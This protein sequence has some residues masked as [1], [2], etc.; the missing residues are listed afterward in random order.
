MSQTFQPL[1]LT[2]GAVVVTF[3]AFILGLVALRQRW[4]ETARAVALDR[5]LGAAAALVYVV[6]V[7][8]PLLPR[9]FDLAWSLPLHICD[10][11]TLCVPL[12]LLW[13]W[14]RPWRPP[15]AILYFWGLG[16]STQGFVTPDL[17]DGPARVGFWMF[18]LAHFS[19]VGGALYDVIG[20]GFRP[21]W[22]DYGVAVA[23]G[24]WYVALVV[25]VNMALGVNYGYVG[26]GTPGQPTLIDALGPWP[27]RVAIIL[28][29]AAAATALLMLPWVI[30]RRFTGRASACAPQ[31]PRPENR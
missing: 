1:S 28:M 17:Q 10:V 18:W 19:V 7:A 14:P 22:R 13:P 15:R 4:R 29:L 16:L 6:T 5:G 11:T 30:G 12:A 3:A 8:W 26:K 21:T 27:G 2:H 31:P 20:R 23:T 24:V 9:H 25:P